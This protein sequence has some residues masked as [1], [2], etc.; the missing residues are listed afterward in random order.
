[1]WDSL[2]QFSIGNPYIQSV[3]FLIWMPDKSGL[4]R[5]RYEI[6]NDLCGFCSFFHFLKTKN[7]FVLFFSLNYEMW[8]PDFSKTN[9]AP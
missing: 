9:L 3:S 6:L 8:V 1:M 7:G 2:L 5:N 4:I